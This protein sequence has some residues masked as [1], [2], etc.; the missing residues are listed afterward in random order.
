MLSNNDKYAI[1]ELVKRSWD[2]RNSDTFSQF[3]NFIARFNHYSRFNTML[4]YLQNSGVTFFGSSSYW[5]KK[6]NRTI[7]K[8]ARPYVILAPM[9]P[10]L[11]VYDVMDTEGIETPEKFLEKGLGRNPFEV[12][13]SLEH[14]T[15]NKAIK[16]I[17]Q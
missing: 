7:S 17:K 11:L 9:S 13:G 1:D 15:Y 4:V 3:F 10:V 16:T 5:R 6:F 8:D 2:L 14:E 12:K